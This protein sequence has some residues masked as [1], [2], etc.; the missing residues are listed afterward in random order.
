MSRRDSELRRHGVDRD[1]SPKRSRRDGNPTAHSNFHRSS[2]HNDAPDYY[3]RTNHHQQQRDERATHDARNNG[4]KPADRGWLSR[5]RDVRDGEKVETES[6]RDKNSKGKLD[7]DNTWR[8]DKFSGVKSDPQSPVRKRPAFSEKKIPVDSDKDHG[9]QSH[10]DRPLSG[11]EKREDRRHLDRP[12]RR[13]PGREMQSGGGND[14]G[15][16]RLSGG[17]PRYNSGGTQYDKWSHDLF[18]EANRSP[19]RKNEDEQ[20]AKV[21]SLLAL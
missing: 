9:K 4:R 8:H 17:R 6:D 1:S 16:D 13:P 7:R 21:E 11:N 2:L 12:Y 20:I 19:P 5:P 18:D 3:S 14:R 10:R 15:R